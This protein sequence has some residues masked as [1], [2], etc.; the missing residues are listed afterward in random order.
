M[1]ATALFKHVM[2]QKYTPKH[3]KITL[4]GRKTALAYNT[5]KQ[6]NLYLDEK[7]EIITFPEQ[8][9]LLNKI[10]ELISKC[11]HKKNCF[12]LSTTYHYQKG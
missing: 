7:I 12:S 4:I 11:R 2:T 5:S 1:Q 8:N 9:K 10:S 3:T 6:C